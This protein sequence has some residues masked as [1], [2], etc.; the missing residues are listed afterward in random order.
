MK[1]TDIELIEVDEQVAPEITEMQCPVCGHAWWKYADGDASAF[2]DEIDPCSHLKFMWYAEGGETVGKWN[3]KKFEAEYKRAYKKYNDEEYGK[4]DIF[5][6]GADYG[7]LDEMEDVPGLELHA[8]TEH[9][10]CC[11]PVAYT[12][13]YGV[14]NTPKKAK[15]AKKK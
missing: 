10:M 6:D 7:V 13:L 2:S 1:T 4:G 8:Y 5:T 11:G 15:K 3:P 9:G 12:T 14:S